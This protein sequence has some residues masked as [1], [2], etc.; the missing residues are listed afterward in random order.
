MVD[1]EEEW[2]EIHHFKEVIMHMIKIVLSEK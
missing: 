2:Q 1:Y